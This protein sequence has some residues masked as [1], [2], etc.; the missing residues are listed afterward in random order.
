MTPWAYYNDHDLQAAEWLRT[1]ID[2]GH[3]APGEVDERSILDVRADELSGF[4]QCHFFAGIGGWSY[5]LRLAGWPDDKPVWT[6]SPPCQPFSV[7]GEGKGA[8][9]ARH[10]APKFAGLVGAARPEVLFGEQVASSAVFGK[11][12]GKAKR[13]IARAPEWAW[14]DDLSDRLEAA[15]YAVGASDIP[16]AGIGAPHIRQRTFFGAYDLRPTASGLEYASSARGPAWI[17]EPTQR[18]KGQSSE[19]DNAMRGLSGP[20]AGRPEAGGL[21]DNNRNRCD[22]TGQHFPETGNDGP[23]GNSTL[24]GL[25]DADSWKCRGIAEHGEHVTDRQARGR[26]QGDGEPSGDCVTDQPAPLNGFWANADWLGCRDGKWRPVEPGSFPLAHGI[27]GRVGLLR[28]YGNA[29]NPWAAKE[30]IETFEEV[31]TQI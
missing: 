8:D 20:H 31:R 30:F 13:R 9:D 16:A 1:L 12:A 23:I 21:A 27:P 25:A 14:L 18:E 5:A 19:P 29:I 24:G 17:P 22:Q 15:Q 2:A 3:I 7:A 6:G 10:L 11:V 26:K 28:G 4:T